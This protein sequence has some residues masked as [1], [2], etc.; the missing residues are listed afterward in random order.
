MN[1]KSKIILI[2]IISVL[3]ISNGILLGLFINSQNSL[4]NTEYSLNSKE[5][6]YIK[7]SNKFD[8]LKKENT[9]RDKD[10]TDLKSQINNLKN[11]SANNV[12]IKKEKPKNIF[13]SKIFSDN[14]K[15]KV[16]TKRKQ[17]ATNSAFRIGA[18]CNDGT[19]SNATGRG[20][21]SWHGGVA[22]WL[23]SDGS[24]RSH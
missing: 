9:S 10:I 11:S 21:C 8:D 12:I 22:F 3:F 23:Y 1:K 4:K 17:H 5:V 15:K 6:D 14:N 20:A 7:L 19:R 18:I 2:S 16:I 13:D 24:K